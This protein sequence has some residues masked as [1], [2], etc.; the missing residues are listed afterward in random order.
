MRLNSLQ[1]QP[2]FNEGLAQTLIN[3]IQETTVPEQLLHA[4]YDIRT[5]NRKLP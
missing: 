4:D 2:Y 5:K 1:K 3:H